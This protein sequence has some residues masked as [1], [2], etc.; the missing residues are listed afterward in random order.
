MQNTLDPI[1]DDD[2]DEDKDDDNCIETKTLT[3][4]L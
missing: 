1:D 2:D 3:T 4:E